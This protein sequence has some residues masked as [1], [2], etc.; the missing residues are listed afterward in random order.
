MQ[1]VF[2]LCS[3]NY[4]SQAKTL[5]QSLLRHNP[6]YKFIIGL[7]DRN[8]RGIDLSFLG[9]LEVLEVEKLGIE[10]FEEMAARYNIVELAT[11]SKPFY[12]DYL[13]RTHPDAEAVTYFDPDIKVFAPLTDMAAKL[14]SSNVILTP[15]ITQPISDDL[16]PSE[17]N[18]LNTGVFNLGFAAMKRGAEADRLNKWWMGKLRHECLVDP[19][20]GYFVDQLWMNL[21]PAFFDKVLI[22]KHPGWNTA[23]WNLHERTIREVDGRFLVNEQPLIFFH[24]SHYSPKQPDTLAKFHTRFSFANRPDVVTLYKQYNDELVA[25]R[26][27][28]LIGVPCFYVSNQR[29]KDFKKKAM[30]WLRQNVPSTVKVRLGKLL[31]RA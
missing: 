8:H 6:D 2:T 13:F 14:K 12:F 5:G 22:E 10:G 31:K 11:A 26:Y 18:V 15:Q 17:K 3:I 19:T 20:R 1:V 24:F 25:N 28:D 30:G 27:L 4:L 7:I 16:L 21:A 29:R 9:D 23:H